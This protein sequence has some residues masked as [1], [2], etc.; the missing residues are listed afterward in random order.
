[1][2]TI[3]IPAAELPA[4]D[5]VRELGSLHR[6]RLETLRHAPETALANHLARTAEL[7]SE[8]LRRYPDREV[9]PSRL[10]MEA[11]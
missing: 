4:E 10:T 3:G 11:P 5:L 9:D 8:Y 2:A 1:M 6:T 7:E